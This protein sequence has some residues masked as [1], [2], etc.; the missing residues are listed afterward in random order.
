MIDNVLPAPAQLTTAVIGAGYWGPN[1]V[2]NLA[3]HPST[4]LAW[5]CDVDRR[6]AERLCAAYAGVQ[7][8]DDFAEILGDPTVHAVAI[9][10]PPSTH[11][12][13]AIAALQAGKHVLVEK[14]LAALLP[15]AEKMV[16]E[17][18]ANHCILMCDHTYCYT[19]A[20][21]YIR[22]MIRGGELGEIQF[23]DS[24][25]INLGIVQRDVDV[26]W[27]L[28]PH[29]L[30]ILDAVLPSHLGVRSVSATGADPISSGQTCIAYLSIEL[31]NGAIAHVHVNWL[32]PIKVR[33]MIIGGSLRTLR[34]DDLDPTQ[35]VSVYDRGVEVS[36]DAEPN[37]PATRQIS[38]RI[39]DMIAP[40]LR[41]REG[42][43]GVVD[44]FVASIRGSRPPLTD[45]HSGL[46]VLRLLEAARASIAQGGRAVPFEGHGAR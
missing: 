4:S 13:L 15:D 14:P 39:G 43:V 36:L 35:R 32:S 29:D 24:V 28:A 1:L 40:A 31:D 16:A 46:R 17:A 30:S 23:I 37:A 2:R 19:P 44:E 22:N 7:P 10:T 18:E 34:W 3:L 42:L 26:V 20:V 9:A 33:T 11:A 8:T 27:D 38:Y 5:V 25:R 41:E 12:E 6:R 45:G 21:Q